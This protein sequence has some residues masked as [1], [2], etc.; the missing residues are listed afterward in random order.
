MAGLLIVGVLALVGHQ[1]ARHRVPPPLEAK[2]CEAAADPD[3]RPNHRFE[4]KGGRTTNAT[5]RTQGGALTVD[6]VAQGRDLGRYDKFEVANPQPRLISEIERDP[7]LA[8]ARTFL[9]EHWRDRRQAYLIV[10][11][12][13]V[14]AT[15]TSHVFVEQDEAGRWRVC[16][17]IVRQTGVIHGLPTAY[18]VEWAIGIGWHGPRT[19]LARGQ[20]PDPTKHVLE[21]RDKCGDVEGSL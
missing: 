8:R 14:D 5:V 21:F 19:P 11:M 10:T 3:E 7:L 1:D 12:S 20:E 16:R 13:S 9:W 4:R 2:N 17:R 15:I 18:S 6:D